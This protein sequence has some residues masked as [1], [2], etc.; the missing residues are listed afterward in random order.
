MYSTYLVQYEYFTSTVVCYSGTVVVSSI[1]YGLFIVR[2]DYATINSQIE[3][4]TVS[5]ERTRTREVVHNVGGVPCPALEQSVQCVA[6]SS[7]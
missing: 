6:D 5:A 7:C 3:S 1:D 2:P 4:K